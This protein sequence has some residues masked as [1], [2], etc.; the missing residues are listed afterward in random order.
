MTPSS[1]SETALLQQLGILFAPQLSATA[2]AH[3]RFCR[4]LDRHALA[5]TTLNHNYCHR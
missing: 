3:R 1:I 4:A 2:L 5:G